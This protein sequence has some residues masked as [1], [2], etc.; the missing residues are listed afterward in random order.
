MIV[1]YYRWVPDFYEQVHE[2]LVGLYLVT[3]SFHQ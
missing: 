1:E 2:P 3:E